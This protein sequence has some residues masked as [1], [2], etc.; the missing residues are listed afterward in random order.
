MI[1]LAHCFRIATEDGNNENEASLGFNNFVNDDG[2]DV[3]Y[4]T[5]TPL[6]DA[7]G[8]PI[9][10][11]LMSF[12]A[13]VGSIYTTPQSEDGGFINNEPLFSGIFENNIVQ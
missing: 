7:I 9:F 2:G 13:S 8:K 11:K 5:V 4:T 12:W 1:S 6:W 10:D 3:S